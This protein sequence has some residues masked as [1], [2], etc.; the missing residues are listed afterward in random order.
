MQ[1]N[2]V[3]RD[4]IL[5]YKEIRINKTSTSYYQIL[6]GSCLQMSSNV[7]NTFLNFK[8]TLLKFLYFCIHG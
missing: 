3:I 4:F 2:Q 5:C 1:L 6:S 7:Y 8:I